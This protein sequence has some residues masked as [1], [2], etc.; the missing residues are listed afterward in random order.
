MTDCIFCNIVAGKIPAQVVYEDEEMLA[1]HDIAPKA[2][3]HILLIPKRHIVNLN[4]LTD[5]DTELVGR[6]LKQAADI[7]RQQ[8]LK[9]FRTITNT[10]KAG[11][12]EVFHLH[13]HLLGGSNGLPGF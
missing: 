11:G 2:E 4:D 1:F 3:T 13:F 8:D 10:E 9:G 6:M 12:Q 5:Q 7:C